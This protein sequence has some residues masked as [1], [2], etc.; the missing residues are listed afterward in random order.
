MPM[1]ALTSVLIDNVDAE[2]VDVA[3]AAGGAVSAVEGVD[4]TKL[5]TEPEAVAENVDNVVGVEDELDVLVD[6][7]GVVAGATEALEWKRLLGEDLARD[8]LRMWILRQSKAHGEEDVTGTIYEL[9]L[10]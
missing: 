5:E 9:A 10:L 1:P 4:V 2:D 8:D 3:A 6:K 7:A